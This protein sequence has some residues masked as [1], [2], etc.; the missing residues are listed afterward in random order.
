[1]ITEENLWFIL[2]TNDS[3]RLNVYL[4][5]RVILTS[6]R[7]A[8]A[9]PYPMNQQ[10]QLLFHTTPPAA[11]ANYPRCGIRPTAAPRLHALAPFTRA[12]SETASNP[13]KLY[14]IQNPQNIT[15]QNE[16]AQS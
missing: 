9:G 10:T 16:D 12:R 15:E 3:F 13:R 6:D 5:I 2:T 4:A 7:S 1:M 11:L 8:F 14:V